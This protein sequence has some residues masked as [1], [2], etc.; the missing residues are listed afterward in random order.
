MRSENGRGKGKEECGVAEVQNWWELTGDQRKMKRNSALLFETVE[1][2][3]NDLI[4]P[5][6]HPWEMSC[7]F[8]TAQSIGN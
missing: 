7:L 2:V 8:D 3:G 5:R 1:A 6:I 4:L